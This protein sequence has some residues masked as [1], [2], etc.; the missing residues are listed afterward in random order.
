MSMLL[1]NSLP[2]YFTHWEGGRWKFDGNI[3]MG[4][5]GG[6]RFVGVRGFH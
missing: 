6:K 1:I 2:C 5:I 3:Y 4:V